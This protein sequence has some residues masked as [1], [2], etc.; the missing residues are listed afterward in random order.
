MDENGCFSKNYTFVCTADGPA[1]GGGR[2]ECTVPQYIAAIMQMD[3][4]RTR[5]PRDLPV[6]SQI[7]YIRILTSRNVFARSVIILHDYTRAS[8]GFLVCFSVRLTPT[9]TT[10]KYFAGRPY[11]RPPHSPTY[12]DVCCMINREKYGR[13]AV[14][15]VRRAAAFPADRTVTNFFFTF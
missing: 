3:R 5:G 13:P 14:A 15:I 4:R 8:D 7:G 12:T 9:T 11:A 6:I 1:G 10:I 2:P